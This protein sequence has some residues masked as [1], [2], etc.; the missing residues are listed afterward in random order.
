MGIV[1]CSFINLHQHLHIPIPGLPRG[2]SL[3]IQSAARDVCQMIPL[4]MNIFRKFRLALFD[5]ILTIN[6]ILYE[7][8]SCS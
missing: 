2:L 1:L 8:V 7:R 5:Y 4:E 3:V 6:S